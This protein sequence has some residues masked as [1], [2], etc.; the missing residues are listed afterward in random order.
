MPNELVKKHV[1]DF[2]LRE[3]PNA[4]AVYGFGS[5]FGGEPNQQSDADLAVLVDGHVDP[6]HLWNVAQELAKDIGTDVD[7]IDL[8]GASTVLQYQVVTKG[9]RLWAKDE[10]ADLYESFILGEKTK[11]NE[12]R[13]PLMK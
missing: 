5:R 6:L 4:L 7:L 12:A 1:V 11:L 2:L 10:R 9:V 8:R 3:F 13:E